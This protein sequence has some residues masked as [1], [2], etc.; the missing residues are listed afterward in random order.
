M[1]LALLTA[2][3]IST[4]VAEPPVTEI[5]FEEVE[6][7]GELVKPQLTLV[8]LRTPA[9]FEPG[10]LIKTFILDPQVRDYNP[11]PGEELPPI[12]DLELLK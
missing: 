6:L 1:T 10:S 7:T 5:D 8:Q 9:K 3:S 2:L 12:E 4:A 11:K